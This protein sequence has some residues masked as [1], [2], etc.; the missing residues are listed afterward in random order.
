MK[1]A[2]NG[3]QLVKSSDFQLAD[4]IIALHK[5]KDEWYVIGEL[6]KIW[7]ERWPEEVPAFKKQIDQYRTTL[8]DRKFGTTAK[9][10]DFGRRLILSFPVRLQSLIRIL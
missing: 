6:V 5:N 3:Y 10:E 8:K 4:K 9:G 7:A 1:I 2:D